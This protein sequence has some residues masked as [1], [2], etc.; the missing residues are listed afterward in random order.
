MDIGYRPCLLPW[1]RY[2]S[3]L[4]RNLAAAGLSVSGKIDPDD[5]VSLYTF[6]P[7]G[8]GICRITVLL[9]TSGCHG[10]A[11]SLQRCISSALF[12]TR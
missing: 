2:W 11:R 3:E 5:V 12:Y 9:Y 4:E 7:K 10:K 8:V 6:Y 1:P